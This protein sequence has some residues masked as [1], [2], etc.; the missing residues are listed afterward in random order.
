MFRFLTASFSLGVLVC[1]S[2]MADE[3]PA[4]PTKVAVPAKVTSAPTPAGQRLTSQKVAA[5]YAA[6]VKSLGEASAALNK[7]M[8]MAPRN[9]IQ[10]RQEELKQIES[11]RAQVEAALKTLDIRREEVRK[12]AAAEAVALRARATPS[13]ISGARMNVDRN[14]TT[15]RFAVLMPGG[16]LIVEVDLTRDG[17]PFRLEREKLLDEMLA[18]ADTNKDDKVEWTEALNSARFTLGRIRF[19]DTT[20]RDRLIQTFDR[21]RN[22]VVERSEAR[23][24]MARYF[25]GDTFVL[26]GT[27]AARRYYGAQLLV[28]NGRVVQQG[29]GNA[30]VTSLLDTNKDGA[31]DQNE[32]AAAAKR[33]K[34]RDADDNDL[35]YAAEIN[36]TPAPQGVRTAVLAAGGMSRTAQAQ[37]AVLLGPA[38]TAEAV[39]RLLRLQYGTENGR[40]SKA[41]FPAD[42]KLFE[43]LDANQDGFFE[44]AEVALLNKVE[45]HVRLKANVGMSKGR[46]LTVVES[47]DGLD[48]VDESERSVSIVRGRVRVTF[49]SPQ[50]QQRSYRFDVTAQAYLQRFDGDSNGYLE[51]DEVQPGL[52]QQFDLWDE[53]EDGKVFK[54]EIESALERMQAPQKSQLRASATKQGNP[55]FSAIDRSGDSRLSLREMRTA[56]ERIEEFDVN[57]DGRITR[58]EIPV[59][60]SVTFSAGII[61]YGYVGRTTAQAAPRVT[62]DAPG[63][64]VHM[65]RNGDGDVT[66][67]EFPGTQDFFDQLD[68]N[69]DGFI[70]PKEARAAKQRQ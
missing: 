15:E 12:A 53:N 3:P 68:T 14:D 49:T 5:Q 26:T 39:I 46:W 66:I 48:R 2:A 17:K 32:I 52:A 64:F 63:W 51:K 10:A 24:M 54:K 1:N 29:S 45:P 4:K 30:D 41:G 16:P 13:I 70:E 28:S 33:L 58:D 22:G 35:L 56:D 40:I 60:M 31:I 47:A 36:G 57:S 9:G 61:N 43:Q 67:K 65:D 34:S 11:A 20:Q 27:P 50:E 44:V 55:L 37:A 7:A 8:Q 19:G 62:T 69:D 38:T 18:A 23:G 59:S 42:P 21:N 6:A 25:Q